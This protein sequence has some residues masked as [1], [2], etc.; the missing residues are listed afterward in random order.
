VIRTL[1]RATDELSASQ[2]AE[3][4]GVSQV[5]ARRYLEHLAER[6]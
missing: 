4:V 5:T 3:D 1:Q 6:R 2:V